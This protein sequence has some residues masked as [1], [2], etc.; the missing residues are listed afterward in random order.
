MALKNF[1]KRGAK[2]DGGLFS[3]A[4]GSVAIRQLHHAA[5]THMNFV[6]EHERTNS[7]SATRN[8]SRLPFLWISSFRDLSN[9]LKNNTNSIR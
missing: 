8:V 1:V 2:L 4:A 9:G 7:A 3:R 6:S 5:T